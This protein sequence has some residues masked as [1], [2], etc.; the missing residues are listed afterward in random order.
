MSD[1]LFKNAADAHKV[2]FYREMPDLSRIYDLS[3]LNE[4]LL[5]KKLSPVPAPH[6]GEKIPIF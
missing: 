3:V 4:V 6:P 2:G 1:S 5:E